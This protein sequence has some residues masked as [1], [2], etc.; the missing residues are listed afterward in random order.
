MLAAVARGIMLRARSG[1]QAQDLGKIAR[2][3]VR[4]SAREIT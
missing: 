3:A 1:A 2:V 4:A